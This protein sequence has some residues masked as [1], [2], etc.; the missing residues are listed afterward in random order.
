LSKNHATLNFFFLL[1]PFLRTIFS[2]SFWIGVKTGNGS[3]SGYRGSRLGIEFTHKKSFYERN[4]NSQLEV[5]TTIESHK[6]C[7][8]NK[9]EK[10]I[11]DKKEEKLPLN[12]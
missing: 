10:G 12:R 8:Y 7:M 6:T 4:I 11:K 1:L 2:L 5:E 3:S 9:Y